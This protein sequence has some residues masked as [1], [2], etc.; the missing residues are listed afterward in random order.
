[1]AERGILPRELILTASAR[2]AGGAV[3]FGG[4]D[5][6]VETVE[7]CIKRKPNVAVFCAG[8]Q[9]SREWA[10][11]FVEAGALVID[12]SS[13]WRSDPDCP[14]VVPQVNPVALESIPKGIVASPNCS[15]AG[16]VIALK[17]L[18]ER[19]GEPRHIFVATYQSVSGAGA[20]GNE[21]LIRQRNGEDFEGIFPQK[22]FDNVIPVIGAIDA[23]GFNIE[24]TKLA[25]ETRKIL[26]MPNLHITATAV[27]VPIIACHSE[28]VT[29][30]FAS[31]ASADEAER[32]LEC[33][34][35]LRLM[36]SPEFPTPLSAVDFDDVLVGR[37]RNT[38]GD[39]SVLSMF[40][41]FDNLRR[42]AA[43][44]AV[45]LIEHLA[46]KI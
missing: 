17:P 8:G 18:I 13:A 14:L 40:I 43:T 41:C 28:A 11:K 2:S 34:P 35:G 38:P 33:A 37:I 36:K 46:R 29:I 21:A 16:F 26:A 4:K 15:T 3:R 7:G 44:N 20:G 25:D 5:Y 27:R 12:K 42:G 10:P 6:V 31:D 9:V 32:V 39:R 30:E 19:F 45:D 22:I 24:E 1:M 23:N